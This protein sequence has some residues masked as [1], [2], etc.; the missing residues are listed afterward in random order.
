MPL[1]TIDP[2]C[3]LIVVDLQKGLAAHPEVKEILGNAAALAAEFRAR[4]LPVVLVTV[5]GG[6]PGR[7]DQQRPGGAPRPADWAEVAPELDRQPGDLHVTKQRWGAF[8]GTDL[9]RLLQDRG[10]TQTVLAGV[11]TS[12]GVESTARSAHEHGYHVVLATDAMA[13]LDPEAHRHSIER[14][15]P[16]L[17]ET[18]AT[19]DI[20]AALRT[21]ND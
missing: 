8:T 13:D 18:A 7:T 1:S 14:I 11:A 19:A 10:V 2:A 4:E 5:D 6:A 12:I 21:R 16:R 17:G 9:H 3:A 15:F 20:L